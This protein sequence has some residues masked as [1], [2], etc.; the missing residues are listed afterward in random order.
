LLDTH[1]VPV[2]TARAISTAKPAANKDV[3]RNVM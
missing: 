1:V 3:S 2:A